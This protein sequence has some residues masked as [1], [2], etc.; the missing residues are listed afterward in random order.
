MKVAFTNPKNAKLYREPVPVFVDRLRR[1]IN[2]KCEIVYPETSSEEELIELAKD[3]DII[4]RGMGS[5]IPQK[6]LDAA[7]KVKLIQTTEVGVEKMPFDYL[8]KRGIYLSNNSGASAVAVAEHAFTLMLILAKK[9]ITRHELLKQGVWDR[10]R[11]VELRGKTV[12]IVGLGNVG[13]EL[14]K[15]AKAFGMLVMAIKRHPSPDLAKKLGLNFLGGPTDLHKILKKSDFVVLT[16]PSIPETDGLIGEKE[17][18]L[19][20]SSAFII[21]VARGGIIQEDV[22]Y[23]ALKEKWIA[24]AG[25]DT[26]WAFDPHIPSKLGIH[27]LDNVVA[28]SHVGGSTTEFLQNVTKVLAQNI[29]RISKNENPLKL[30]NLD[31]RY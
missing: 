4:V 9:V 29:E 10:S 27:K 28:T 1:T 7:H 18:R 31:L 15:R 25:I 24:G 20:K 16:I 17:L 3:A 23:K 6:V 5:S 2:I 12:G 13:T 21:N 14:A 8:K 19:M 30:V 22:L 26:W 11:S